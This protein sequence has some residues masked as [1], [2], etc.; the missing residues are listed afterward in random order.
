MKITPEQK[1]KI[2]IFTF[3]GL[4]VLV[5]AVFFIG[6]QKSLFSSTIKLSGVFTNVNGL[7]IGNNVRF[8]G[9]NVGVV[10]DIQIQNDTAVR[11]TLSVE[12]DVQKFI[13]K[14]AKMNIGSDGLMG[15]KLMVISPGGANTTEMVKD[16]QQIGAV[17]PMD[18]DKIITKVTKMADDAAS[19][20]NSL[21]QI[22]D[23]IN[24][25][26]GSI[27]R[28]LNDNKMADQ[29]QTTV[30]QA[31]KTMKNVRATSAT[32]NEDL[33]AAQSNFLLKGYFNKKKKAEQKRLDS[34][35]KVQEKAQK[36]KEKA[37]KD[38]QKAAEKAQEEARKAA[39]KAAGN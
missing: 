3:V 5:F 8:A 31:N 15:D 32:L 17:N 37:Q 20:F 4:A 24:N 18:V 27:G 38:A 16:G 39:E 14:D 10:D 26:Q 22:V 1:T 36:A 19:L 21:S 6:N 13:K 12:R 35:K 7:Q 2:G 25:G 30:V 33:K 29:I 28:L 9:I 11:V 34:I 23:K